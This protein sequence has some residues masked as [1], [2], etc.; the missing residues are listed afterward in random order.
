MQEVKNV[1]LECTYDGSGTETLNDKSNELKNE[2]IE[3]LSQDS[4][5]DS[6]I[7]EE[8]ESKGARLKRQ[9]AR[10]PSFFRSDAY[11][12]EDMRQLSRDSS[13]MYDDD[14]DEE[15]YIRE[16]YARLSRDND[17]DLRRRDRSSSRASNRSNKEDYNRYQKLDFR[18]RPSSL[19]SEEGQSWEFVRNERSFSKN[20]ELR[21]SREYS[22]RLNRLFVSKLVEQGPSL[23]DDED[24][25]N[26]NPDKKPAVV[27]RV[28]DDE[29]WE[30]D[31]RIR[32]GSNSDVIKDEEMDSLRRRSSAE[33]KIALLQ[34]PIDSGSIDFWTVS[35]VSQLGSSLE[36]SEPEDEGLLKKETQ[37]LS[38]SEDDGSL[39]KDR[40]EQSSFTSDSQVTSTED[41]DVTNFD[42]VLRKNS[43]R[44]TVQDLSKLSPDRQL[45]RTDELDSIPRAASGLFKRESIIKSQASEEDPEYLLPER[46]KLQEQDED[47]PFKKAWQQQKSRS[48]EDGSASYAIKE[49]KN[50]ETTIKTD[51]DSSQ[52][53]AEPSGEK[54]IE[55]EL[56]YNWQG[57]S[58]EIEEVQASSKL[59]TVE[60]PEIVNCTSEEERFS[61]F[62]VLRQKK[63]AEDD[64]ILWEVDDQH[65]C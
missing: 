64:C 49:T 46:P 53:D 10:K 23:G 54:A 48:E 56:N 39:N 34:D 33:G 19:D 51:N 17:L 44:I 3:K 37:E 2:T 38:Q 32:R 55:Y 9:D 26:L 20:K 21:K 58:I 8:Q 36:P 13:M 62:R 65:E 1:L 30:D 63:K 47:H 28:S 4:S 29:D 41:E 60:N 25:L 35:K 59:E 15:L 18:D 5:M 52:N 61:S 45:E 50:V 16:R 57:R 22:P 7:Y 31:M 42:F 14:D 43:K 12:S 6:E 24:K 40:G 27:P 11:D